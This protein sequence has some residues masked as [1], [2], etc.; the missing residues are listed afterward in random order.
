[1]PGMNMG[2]GVSWEGKPLLNIV[3]QKL[4]SYDFCTSFVLHK[5]KWTFGGS[6]WKLGSLHMQADIW[7]MSESNCH[8]IGLYRKTQITNH[9]SHITFLYPILEGILWNL[10]QV[11][12]FL[13]KMLSMWSSIL[14]YTNYKSQVIKKSSIFR[15]LL[16]HV[17]HFVIC[18]L[19]FMVYTCQWKVTFWFV[20]WFF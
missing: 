14:T 10:A 19:C 7:P 3:S 5:V 18:D 12:D 2:M 15:S 11:C 1:M 9:I 4:I 16:N 8:L 13:H 20:L 6:K 17:Q